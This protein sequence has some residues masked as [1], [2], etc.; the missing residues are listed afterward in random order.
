MTINKLL[1]IIAFTI[2]YLFV[3][4]MFLLFSPLIICCLPFVLIEW[5]IDRVEDKNEQR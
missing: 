2:Y 4:S 5:A 1:D 3:S